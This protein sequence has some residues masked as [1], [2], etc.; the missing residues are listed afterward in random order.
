MN[1][2]GL[3]SIHPPNADMFATKIS[4]SLAM[5]ERLQALSNRTQQGDHDTISKQQHCQILDQ[6]LMTTIRAT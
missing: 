3:T 4:V 2:S 1:A 6:T 5:N